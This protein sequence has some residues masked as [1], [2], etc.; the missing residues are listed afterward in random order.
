MCLDFPD[1]RL[2]FDVSVPLFLPI[3]GATIILNYF[4][5]E[6]ISSHTD[7]ITFPFS[8]PMW[9]GLCRW[10]FPGMRWPVLGGENG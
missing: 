4:L 2:R 3:A 5:R 6:R 10:R 1:L 8:N 7:L 9:R